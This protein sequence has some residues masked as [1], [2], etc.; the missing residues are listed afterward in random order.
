MSIT[1]VNV[2][3]LGYYVGSP[4]AVQGSTT[5]FPYQAH[6]HTLKAEFSSAQVSH[7]CLTYDK[8]MPLE[9]R[10]TYSE[11]M[12]AI[13]RSREGSPP[14]KRRAACDECRT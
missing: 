8:M 7:A 1:G 13:E 2:G 9:R 12:G 4:I 11:M 14:P 3:R 10:L 6:Q 5:P